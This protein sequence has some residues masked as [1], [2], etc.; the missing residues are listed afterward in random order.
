VA[1]RALVRPGEYVADAAGPVRDGLEGAADSGPDG[2]AVTWAALLAVLWL[3][4][5]AASVLVSFLCLDAIQAA[6]K[7]P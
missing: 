1:L 6:H 3:P 4:R 5:I 7:R 2:G